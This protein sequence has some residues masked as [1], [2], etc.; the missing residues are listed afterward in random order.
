MALSLDS[1]NREGFI[2]SGMLARAPL[3]GGAPREILDGVEA[4][5]WSPDGS[6]LAVV[7]YLGDK[8][9]LEFP[10]GKVLYESTGW[11]ADVRFSPDGTLY[12]R[13]Y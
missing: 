1:Y 2:R 9:R 8:E 6:R 5:S 4:A 7:R 12:L 11:I 3:A 13:V 10:I